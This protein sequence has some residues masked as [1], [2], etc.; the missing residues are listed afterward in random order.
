MLNPTGTL[1]FTCGWKENSDW[2]SYYAWE[3]VAG[4][5]PLYGMSI[6]L[7]VNL[8]AL[9]GTAI[10][11]PAA[12]TQY[13]AGINLSVEIS[14]QVG[15]NGRAAC[16]GVDG[17]SAPTYDMG[18]LADGQISVQ[19]S[20]SAVIGNKKVLSAQITGACK[21]GFTLAVTVSIRDGVGLVMN[22][23]LT[24]NGLVVSVTVSTTA[25]NVEA[26]NAQLGAWT[27]WNPWSPPWQPDSPWV[28]VGN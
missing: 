19:V 18:M 4:I 28:L 6:K 5:E 21:S 13:A 20:L 3:I 14:G 23:S 25:F 15:V 8:L 16:V 1:K 10:A 22:P 2:Q 11:I 12:L 26:A 9:A 27:I 7:T 24:W 17:N